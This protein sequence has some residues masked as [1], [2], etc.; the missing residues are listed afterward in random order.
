MNLILFQNPEKL[1]YKV[2]HKIQKATFTFQLTLSLILQLFSCKCGLLNSAFLSYFLTLILLGKHSPSP[3]QSS[4]VS[5]IPE[6]SL[7]QVQFGYRRQGSGS[8][9]KR[10]LY[11]TTNCSLQSVSIEKNLS[12][13]LR[14]RNTCSSISI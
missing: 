8:E 1:Q 14:H 11:T 2:T 10:L 3:S 5:S 7:V 9:V 13:S 4:C 6:N 12:F